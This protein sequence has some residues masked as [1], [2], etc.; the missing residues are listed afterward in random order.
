MHAPKEKKRVHSSSMVSV[1]SESP[2]A[3]EAKKGRTPQKSSPPQA[4]DRYVPRR[5]SDTSAALYTVSDRV[6]HDHELL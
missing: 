4:Y 2:I 3:K 6:S 1:L 5:I